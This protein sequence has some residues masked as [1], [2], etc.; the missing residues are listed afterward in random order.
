MTTSRSAGAG[1]LSRP[2]S[3]P[4]RRRAW[5]GRLPSVR[6]A[7]PEQPAVEPLIA[8]HR[9]ACPDGDFAELRRAYTVAERQHRGVLRKSGAPYITHPLAVAM[10]L[11]ALGMDT[12]TLVAALLH[13]TVEDTPYTLGEVRADFGEDVAVLVDGVTKLDGE[14]WDD[15]AF[16][17]LNPEAYG[18]THQAAETAMTIRP[19]LEPALDRMRSCLA[20]HDVTAQVMTRPRH[21]YAVYV[22]RGGD[23]DGLRPTDVAR[24]LVLVDGSDQDC[25]VAACPPAGEVVALPQGAT[26]IDFA[27]A[28]GPEIGDHC[29]GVVINGR[30][31]ALSAEVRSGYVVEILTAPDA[32]PGGGG[33][34]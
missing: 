11:A 6:P 30:L 12:T 33:D 1:P 21:L 27:Y 26:A 14:R 9:A 5:P 31:A 16:A 17:A 32:G 15:L 24:I 25:Y 3:R 23:V 2:E 28:L 7:P 29:I 18:R 13:D 34:P 4:A 8:A 10:I 22:E 20:E 19:G